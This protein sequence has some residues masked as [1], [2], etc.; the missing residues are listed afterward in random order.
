MNTIRI[1]PVC[2]SETTRLTYSPYYPYPVCFELCALTPDEMQFLELV[3]NGA[4]FL[5]EFNPRRA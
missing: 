4:P 2:H 1:C 3:S 5:P